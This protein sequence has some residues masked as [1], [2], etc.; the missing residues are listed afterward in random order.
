[1]AGAK[2]PGEKKDE[3]GT[4]T[5]PCEFKEQDTCEAKEEEAN[6]CAKEETKT[7][8]EEEEEGAEHN[9]QNTKE[10]QSSKKD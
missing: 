9:S 4:G 6:K 10:I 7:Q 8:K 2:K 5:K 1:M 3:T